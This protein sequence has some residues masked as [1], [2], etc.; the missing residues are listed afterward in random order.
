MHFLLV[1]VLILN[2]LFFYGCSSSSVRKPSPERLKKEPTISLYVKET[3]QKKQLKMEEYVAGVVAAEMDTN[4]PVNALA[5]QAIIA[6]TYTMKNMETGKIKKLH[7]TDA[8][9][10]IEEFQ[11]YDAA[12]INS[13]VRKAVRMTRGQVITYKGKYPNAWF[14]ACCG[15]ITASAQEGL[16]FTQEA[17]PYIKAGVRDN[18]L[19]IT[20]P[21]N[22]HWQASVPKEKVLAAVRQLTGANP[23][24]LAPVKITEKG[25][26]GRAVKI[27]LGD[28][29]L[30]G[31]ALRNAVGSD[32]VRSMLLNRLFMQGNNVVFTGKGFG[33]G[34]G[35]CQWGANLMAQKGKGPEDIINFYYQGVQIEKKWE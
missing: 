35:L 29:E 14:S 31:P 16:A 18:C 27:K 12:K 6:R 30:G 13:N 2:S 8:S 34:V 15:G 26:S 23:G 25:D 24:S 5:A 17:T 22:R 3:G 21:E 20:V 7:G 19:S 9:T 4:W 11:A 33:H 1:T 10:D 32:V 28:T